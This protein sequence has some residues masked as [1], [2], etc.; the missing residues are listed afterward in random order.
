[1]SQWSTE[2][3]GACARKRKCWR[4]LITGQNLHNRP[5]LTSRI[6]V[7]QLHQAINTRKYPSQAAWSQIHP[8]PVT[9]QQ[10]SPGEVPREFRKSLLEPSTPGEE[11]EAALGNTLTRA[12][13]CVA[14]AS[15]IT[16]QACWQTAS[17]PEVPHV[18]PSRPDVITLHVRL[19]FVPACKTCFH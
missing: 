12:M 6:S 8:D 1:M 11:A 15:L 13:H 3:R 17:D 4:M 14:I 5:P 2:A 16:A 19:S 9:A 10:T 7:P 18:F